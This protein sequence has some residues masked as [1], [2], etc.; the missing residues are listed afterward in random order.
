M[1]RNYM[2]N[3]QSMLRNWIDNDVVHLAGSGGPLSGPRNS[4]KDISGSGAGLSGHGSF[5]TNSDNGVVYVNEGTRKDPYW[6]PVDFRQRALIGAYVDWRNGV[7]NP[8]A[9]TNASVTLVESG[10]RTFGSGIEVADSGITIASALGGPIATIRASAGA[11]K[12]V[13]L[14]LDGINPAFGP[15]TEGPIVIDAIVSMVA[16]LT[17]R[18]FFIGFIS[19]KTGGGGG[20]IIDATVAPVTGAV[21]TLTLVQDDVF[22]LYMDVG[23]TAAARLFAPH[24]KADEAPTIAAT[25][26]GVDTGIDFP[27]AATYVRLRVEIT[28]LGHMLC[29]VNKVLATSILLAAT[30]ATAVGPI[31]Y[32]S[33]T[34]A[35]VKDMTCKQFATWGTRR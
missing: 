3:I 32:L 15:D 14:G 29:F 17:L 31:L 5:Y 23:M 6:T 26:A 4:N 19:G 9:D 2:R 27:A 11:S 25:A 33:S 22:G 10:V 13:C 34:S 7:G 24:N 21:V 16:A 8:L 20:T 30:P 18:T 12:F 35:A 1:P 28:K